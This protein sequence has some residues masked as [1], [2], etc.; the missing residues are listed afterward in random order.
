ML[1]ILNILRHYLPLNKKY[2]VTQHTA[3]AYLALDYG[4]RQVS[5]TRVLLRMKILP[6]AVS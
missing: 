5:I 2:F 3:F 1:W 4:L 6:F